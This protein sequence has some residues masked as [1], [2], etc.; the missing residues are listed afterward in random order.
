LSEIERYGGGGRVEEEVVE[1]LTLGGELLV[2]GEA[3]DDGD[4]GTT[5][6]DELG[7]GGEGEV[8][9]FGEFIFRISEGP[10]HS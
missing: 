4:I 6:G 8:D 2:V 10:F 7:A 3:E 1:R 9:E 5:A